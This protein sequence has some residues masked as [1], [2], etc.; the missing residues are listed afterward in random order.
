MLFKCFHVNTCRSH[1]STFAKSATRHRQHDALKG[2]HLQKVSVCVTFGAPRFGTKNRS[3]SIC[4]K[5]V[6]FSMTFCPHV[7]QTTVCVAPRG[8]RRS[9][10][11]RL[12]GG[13]LV[14]VAAR[15]RPKCQDEPALP[16]FEPPRPPRSTSRARNAPHNRAMLS[17]VGASM[18]CNVCTA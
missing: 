7:L 10:P 5:Y 8:R 1:F 15:S 12:C 13:I 2:A 3:F 6:T 17:I 14:A 9:A 11:S 4:S 16:G 18:E